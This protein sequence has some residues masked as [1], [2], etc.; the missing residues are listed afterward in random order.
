MLFHYDV[1]A[2]GQPEPSTFA[3]RFRREIWVENLFPDSWWDARTIVA[4]ADLDLFAEISCHCLQ[5]GF[6]AVAGYGFFVGDRVFSGVATR[7]IQN[8]V[9]MDS[10]HF[11]SAGSTFNERGWIM[12]FS[13]Q[14]P[15]AYWDGRVGSWLKTMP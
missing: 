2:H 11:V 4:D 6:E 10:S 9:A 7:A 14:R 15:S 13:L 3:G 5:L 12:S 1:M 8:I